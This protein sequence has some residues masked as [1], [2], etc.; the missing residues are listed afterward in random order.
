MNEIARFFEY[1]MA[2]E[3]ALAKDDWKLIEPYFTENAVYEITGGAPFAGTHEGREAVLS[4]LQR[5][6]N[7]LDRRFAER[8]VEMRG[9]PSMKE[10]AVYVEWRGTYRASG[11][12]DLVM[13]GIELAWFEGDR[14]RRLEDRYA[15]AELAKIVDYIGCYGSKLPQ[16]KK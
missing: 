9:E 1:A 15:G 7:G 11:V 8:V 5:S 16:P 14:I 13:D 3:E 6:V 10:G 4:F 2:F 12:P